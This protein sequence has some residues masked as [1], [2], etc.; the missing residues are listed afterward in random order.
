MTIL[1]PDQSPD[2]ASGHVFKIARQIALKVMDGFNEIL[3]MNSLWIM[4][5]FNFGSD[6]DH[7]RDAVSGFHPDYWLWRIL[8]NFGAEMVPMTGKSWVSCR[9]SRSK[10]KVKHNSLTHC[11]AWP[12]EGRSVVH[13]ERSWPAIQAAPTDNCSDNWGNIYVPRPGRAGF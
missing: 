7:I 9:S 10:V 13:I 6:I 5:D 4:E 8:T 11:C 3:G 12:A 1:Y 2:S